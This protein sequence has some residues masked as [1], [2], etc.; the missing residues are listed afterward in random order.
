MICVV[1]IKT[2]ASFRHACLSLRIICLFAP[3]ADV[4]VGE[5][6]SCLFILPSLLSV[7]EKK[8]MANWESQTGSIQGRDLTESQK[9]I[10]RT[11]RNE[12]EKDRS[13]MNLEKANPVFVRDF[14]S[15]FPFHSVW[16]FC[17]PAIL[18]HRGLDKAHVQLRFRGGP[19]IWDRQEFRG[20]LVNHL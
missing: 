11:E 15:F 16:A 13:S 1:K 4:T 5:L 18:E 7:K 20:T 12:H 9:R 8:S 2:N 3:T 17:A 6:F 14:L 19:N 10:P